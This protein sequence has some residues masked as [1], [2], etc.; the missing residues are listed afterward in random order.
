MTCHVNNLFDIWQRCNFSGIEA[1]EFLCI[2][3]RVQPAAE[4]LTV[5]TNKRTKSIQKQIK[6]I[7]VDK[8]GSKNLQRVNPVS[9]RINRLLF[10]RSNLQASETHF[11]F[12]SVLVHFSFLSF[13][14]QFSQDIL[15]RLNIVAGAHYVQWKRLAADF[16]FNFVAQKF[17]LSRFVTRRRLFNRKVNVDV[18]MRRINCAAPTLRKRRCRK[19]TAQNAECRLTADHSFRVRKQWDYH[20]HVGS[21]KESRIPKRLYEA[22]LNW[23]RGF[24]LRKAVHMEKVLLR[25]VVRINENIF[26]SSFVQDCISLESR[27]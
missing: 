12:K 14:S 23:G 13:S 16:P 27:F 22:T 5:V 1:L 7:D 20:C 9:C 2:Y 3:T 25:Q 15:L 21:S 10:S 24:S 6:S 11:R 18:K 26:S 17:S 8:V 19:W 4:V